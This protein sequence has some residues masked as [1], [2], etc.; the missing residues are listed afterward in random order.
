VKRNTIRIVVALV[1][2]LSICLATAV[3]AIAGDDNNGRAAGF[4]SGAGEWTFDGG[5]YPY[6]WNLP[7]YGDFVF[8]VQE[9]HHGQPPKGFQYSTW[10]TDDIDP[11]TPGDQLYKMWILDSIIDVTVVSRDDGTSEVWVLSEIT[12]CSDPNYVGTLHIFAY[13]DGG[14]P[15]LNGDKIFA[16]LAP[17]NWYPGMTPQGIYEAG[18]AGA[19]PPFDNPWLSPVTKGDVVVKPQ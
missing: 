11:V 12:A 17:Y 13:L 18:V 3:P 1:L 19:P 10:I 7:W 14:T 6:P 15:G 2:V 9:A 4:A 5:D 8:H 16:A